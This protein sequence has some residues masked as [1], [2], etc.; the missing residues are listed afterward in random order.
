MRLSIVATFYQSAS[1]IET[2]HKKATTAAQ[3][4]VGDDYDIVYVNDGSL[5]NSLDLAIQITE[6][7]PHVV[8]VDLSR[9]F[10]H[11]KAMMTSLEHARGERVFLIGSDLEEDPEWLLSFACRMEQT[12]CDVVSGIQN[13]RKGNLFDRQSGQWFY[14]FFR[15]V[16]GLAIPKLCDSAL[17]EA[18]LC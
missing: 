1:Y 9:N 10:D 5:D 12:T 4:L 18:V 3:K 17:D 7:Y 13:R 14:R 11:H 6:H 2:F 8:L 15:V 16:T